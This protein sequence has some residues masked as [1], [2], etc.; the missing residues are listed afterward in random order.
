MD[1]EIHP[2]VRKFLSKPLPNMIGKE[3]YLA[4]TNPVINPS[5]GSVLAEVSM[6]T[7]DEINRAVSAAEAGRFLHGP[8]CLP[9]NVPACSI[10][11]AD[12]LWPA[13][14]SNWPNSES[15]DVGKPIT[16]AEEFDIPFGIECFRYFAKIAPN[17]IQ[18]SAAPLGV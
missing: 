5:D 13:T 11:F 10:R 8:A 7:T 16:A 4:A 6:G 17:A 3:Q 14:P 12:T 9:L 2:N 18:C 15:L 1:M